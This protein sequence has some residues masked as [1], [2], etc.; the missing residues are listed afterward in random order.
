MFLHIYQKFSTQT[1]WKL[2]FKEQPTINYSYSYTNHHLPNNL[3]SILWTNNKDRMESFLKG[4]I[5]LIINFNIHVQHKFL[6]NSVSFKPFFVEA[7]YARY[8]VLPEISIRIFRKVTM[9]WQILFFHIRHCWGR[10]FIGSW[11]L[12]KIIFLIRHLKCHNL[13]SLNHV[14][15]LL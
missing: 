3:I 15:I 2:K 1:A 10:N 12:K 14:K 6:H 7:T 9:K 8:K 11:F 5:L 13:I 4:K